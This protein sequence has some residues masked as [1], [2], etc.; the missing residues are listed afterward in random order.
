MNYHKLECLSM[1]SL[2][3]LV[4]CLFNKART[5]PYIEAPERFF[6]RVGSCFTNR[7]QTRLEKLAVDKQQSLLRKSVNYVRKKFYSTGPRPVYVQLIYKCFSQILSIACFLNSHLL[8][9][10]P[11]KRYYLHRFLLSQVRQTLIT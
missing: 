6:N 10:A 5:L 2:S 1:A 7:H 8:Q 3:R 11:L 4:Y 9:R